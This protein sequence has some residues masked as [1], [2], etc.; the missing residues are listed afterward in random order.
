MTARSSFSLLCVPLLAVGLSA[1]ASTTSTSNFKGEQHAVAQT[2]ANLQSH[3]TA[4]EAGKICGADL[5]SANVARL[6]AAP[7]GCTR[8][9]EAQLKE[10]DSF[11]TTVE[12]VQVSG[13]HATALVKS[14]HAGKSALQ[15]LTFVKEGGGWR[16]A[17]LG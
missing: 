16:I 2:V 4:M 17:G 11:E 13:D 15:T 6:N 7:G 3:A 14:T 5:A 8:A 9:I 1:C 12:S 10:I